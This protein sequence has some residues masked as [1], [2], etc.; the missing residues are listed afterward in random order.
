M[1]QLPDNLISDRLEKWVGYGR[2]DSDFW[3]LGIEEGGETTFEQQI[4]RMSLPPVSDNK[5]FHDELN[6]KA[7]APERWFDSDSPLQSTWKGPIRI[8]I[9]A[10]G[11]CKKQNWDDHHD[12]E[13]MKSIMRNYQRNEFGQLNSNNLVGEIMPLSKKALVAWPYHKWTANP[14]LQS[15]E[16]YLEKWLPRRKNLYKQLYLEYTPKVVI[17]YGKKYDNFNIWEIFEEIFSD[18]RNE[19]VIIKDKKGK[20]KSKAFGNLILTGHP[21]RG[22]SNEELHKIG[23]W[24]RDNIL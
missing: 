7:N 4:I 19:K 6:K 22:H 18:N 15:K 10:L 12:N 23:H 21:S 14:T 11:R 24:V 8:L 1:P 20:V 17:G 3:I 13:K 16:K 2:L 9:C 5:K